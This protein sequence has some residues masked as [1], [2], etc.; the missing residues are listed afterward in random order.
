MTMR[1]LPLVAAGLAA[2]SLTGSAMTGAALAQTP[3]APAAPPAAPAPAPPAVEKPPVA[4][5]A[6]P[7]MPLDTARKVAA[8]AEAEARRLNLPATIVVVE[9]GGD[10]VLAQKMDNAPF[11]GFEPARRK[12][13]AAALARRPAGV[14]GGAA[15][16]VLPTS[17]SGS[18]G[19]LITAGGR[20]VGAVGVSAGKLQEE[21]VAKAGAAA[22]K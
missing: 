19:E 14:Q 3:Q 10:V 5:Q 12:A 21:Q 4:P 1:D 17:A 13:R 7:V 9:P 20:V 15:P 18:G 22:I 2:L 8:A 6:G 11:G 16:V